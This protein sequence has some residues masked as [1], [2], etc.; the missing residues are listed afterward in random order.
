MTI[1]LT[2]INGRIGKYVAKGL[3]D[4]G[5]NIIGL[6]KSDR[7]IK[8]LHD[9]TYVKADITNYNELDQALDG[10]SIEMVIH[11]AAIA[12]FASQGKISSDQLKK[13]NCKGALNIA[14]SAQRHGAKKM[15]FASTVDVYGEVDGNIVN[16]D[17]PCNP[18]TAYGE[19]KYEAEKELEK[20][21][22]TIG[23]EL[24]IF[25]F[26]PVYSPEYTFDLDK[27]VLLPKKIGAF[28][29]N[30][31]SQQLSLCS[32]Y[33]VVDSVT[34]FAQGKILPGIYIV[35]DR[36]VLTA[37]ELAFFKLRKDE[38]KFILRIPHCLANAI[39]KIVARLPGKSEERKKVF[40]TN[41]NKLLI[42][43]FFDSSK[44]DRTI[45][46]KWYI[47]NTIGG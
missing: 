18:V 12:H 20:L 16:E 19:S 21:L 4:K 17:T 31:G 1:L 26:T 30:D 9:C 2:G 25:R 34:A 27:R 7:I 42:P 8:E 22:A 28:Y 5:F 45:K 38:A 39:L 15:L 10:L 43:A 29:F 33:N 32:I 13:I 35:S 23:V 40:Y 47:K 36:K 46:M 44:M 6:D 14:I 3:L 24:Y 37:K 11:L 41:I